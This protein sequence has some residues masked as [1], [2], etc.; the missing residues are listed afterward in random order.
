VEVETGAGPD[1][2]GIMTLA[3]TAPGDWL[4]V[5]PTIITMMAGA[6]LLMFRR[7]VHLQAWVA[8]ASLALLVVVSAALLV[9]VAE[10]GP[11]AMTM[12]RWLPPFGISFVADLLGASLVLIAAIVALAVAIYA[13]RD[14]DLLL[15]RYGF[16]PLLLLMMTGV[17]GAFLTGDIFNLYVWFEVLLIASFGLI[18]IGNSKAQ[19]DG[20]VRYALLNI[21][22]TTLFLIATGFL[23]GALGTLNMADIAL[24]VRALD[25][26]VPIRTI[27]ALYILAFGMKAAA[28]PVNFWLPASY[29][30]PASAVSAVFA[31][32]LTKVGVY[33]LLRLLVMLMPAQR[34]LYSEVL[35]AVAIATM[36]TGV[37]GALAQSDIRRMLNFLVISGIG[38]ILAGLAI[39]TAEGVAG[40]I[41][42]AIHSM[43]VITALYLAAG[44]AGRLA[45]SF[46]LRELGGLYLAS[47]F[48]AAL[49][50]VL[51]FAVAGLPPFSGFWPKVVLTQAALVEGRWWLAAA[52]LLTGFLTTIA[53]GRAFIQSFWRGGPAATPDGGIAAVPGRLGRPERTAFLLPLAGLT[54]LAVA[55]GVWPQPLLAVA[56][57]AALGLLDPTDYIESVFREEAGIGEGLARGGND[58]LP[59]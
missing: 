56:D 35:V 20:A 29:H 43:V 17:C 1:L 27:T 55:I 44:V 16:Y 37:L 13:A 22:A 33:A 46:E 32:L 58:A 40:A 38:L 8:I 7:K 59:R 41:F 12:G 39:G 15:R 57:A 18:V 45:A 53:G 42:Y 26:E 4:V 49:F 19:L 36:L 24:K 23:Y 2:T 10:N 21:V 5:G 52:I 54:A 30:T 3:P 50:L 48:F 34:D 47:P 31:G 28:F 14:V 25:E 6:V 9:R 51:V 11:V